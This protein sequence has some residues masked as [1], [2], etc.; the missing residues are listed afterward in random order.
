MTALAQDRSTPRFEGNVQGYPVLAATV[1]YGGALVVLDASGWAK[2]AVTATGLV[3]VGRAERRADNSA[4]GNGDIHVKVCADTFRFA[5]STSTDEITKAEIGDNC[6]LVDDQTVAKLSTGRSV[7]GRVVQVDAQGV[8]VAVGASLTNAPGGSLLAANNLSDVGTAATAF[9]NIK[10]AATTS[11]TGVSELATSAETITGTDT[12]R[13]VTP[14]GAADAYKPGT[15]TFVIGTETAHA[16]NVAIQLT[17]NA[18]A[19][20]AVRGNVFGYLSDDAN[21]DSLAASAPSGGWAIGTDGL[22][23]T[24]V[25]N[26]AARFTSEADGDIDVTITEATAKSFYL[27]LV[28]PDGRLVASAA[29]T[30]AG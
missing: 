19:D 22:L 2:P 21:G 17:D 25:T 8:W 9:A 16:R 18:G 11:A 15:P 4:G 26:K 1:I 10:Q 27:I 13:T 6:Y 20:L 28:L 5:N 23:I 7:A 30:F 24:Q 14:K 12:A 3:C 29:I